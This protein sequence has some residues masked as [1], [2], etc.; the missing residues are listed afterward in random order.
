MKKTK[1]EQKDKFDPQ[2]FLSTPGLGAKSVKYRRG[3]RIYAQGDIAETVMYVQ[4]GSVKLSVV[5]AQ[6]KKVVV[7]RFGRGDFFGEGCMAGQPKRIGTTV[8]VEPTTLLQVRK[9][10]LM[11]AMRAGHELA[12]R[13]IGFLLARNLRI[14][15]DLLGN[16][17]SS[18]EKQ[19]ART[20]L[21]LARYG[22]QA[23][24][25]QILPKV[26][27]ERLATMVGVP[28]SHLDF[29]MNKFKKLGFVEYKPKL[30]VNKSLLT[31]VLHD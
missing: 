25:E 31:V 19:L 18:T 1:I 20:L 2:A 21:L 28:R 16:L 23:Q 10:K 30:K 22:E 6:G 3:E 4:A 11:K 9:E 17:F 26:S 13:F 15:A 5:N 7:A 29:Y 24:P 27:K 12:G 14:E 8:A